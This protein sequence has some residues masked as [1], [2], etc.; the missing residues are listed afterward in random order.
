MN[1]LSQSPKTRCGRRLD[2]SG[3]LSVVRC[4]GPKRN[5]FQ[6]YFEQQELQ[7]YIEDA[8]ETTAEQSSEV[9]PPTAILPRSI[10]SVLLSRI[11]RPQFAKRTSP[12]GKG[13]RGHLWVL[14]EDILR[15]TFVLMIRPGKRHQQIRVGEDQKRT[16]SRLRS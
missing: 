15:G 2:P 4:P 9:L 14:L 10:F 8:L 6:K 3:L 12:F 13:T 7:Q 5:T 16:I 11:L 1:N